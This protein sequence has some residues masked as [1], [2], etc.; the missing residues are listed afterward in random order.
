MIKTNYRRQDLIRLCEDAVV[1]HKK[2]G[3][4]DTSDAHRQ[5]G[6]AWALLK[7]GCKFEISTKGDLKTD[8]ETVWVKIFFT[9]FSGFEAGVE[10]NESE[11]FY[12]PTR[13]R[14][15]DNSREDWY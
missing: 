14:I 2:W 9:G 10:E 1:P 3:N 5:L 8:A 13:K 11:T 7:A 15:K 4:R 6:E 12:L